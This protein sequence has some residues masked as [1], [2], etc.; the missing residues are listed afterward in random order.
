MSAGLITHL[1]IEVFG[2]SI[3]FLILARPRLKVR[4]DISEF[5][6]ERVLSKV[7]KEA[8]RHLRP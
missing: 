5:I 2:L 8:L 3:I 1:Q 4:S 6:E 7:T